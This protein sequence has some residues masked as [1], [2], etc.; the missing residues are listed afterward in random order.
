MN[1]AALMAERGIADRTLP[2]GRYRDLPLS[3]VSRDYIAWLARSSSPKDAVFASFVADA[4]KLQEALD[5]ETI[6]DGV[7]AGR[8]ASGKPHPVYAIE[9]LG[10]IDGVTLHDTLDAALAALS[11]EY[12]VHPETGVRTT[13]DPEDDRILIWEILPTCHKKVVWH[14][15][16]WHWNAEE[17]GLDHG[18]LPGDAHCLYFLACNED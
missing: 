15:S 4:K 3:L 9:R 11:R 10:D 17:F 7:L 16:G 1:L 6:A 8:A 12:P 2:F 14:F 5:A 13:P 18:T